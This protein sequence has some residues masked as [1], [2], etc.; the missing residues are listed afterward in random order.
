VS[1]VIC[2][3]CGVREVE[4][5]RKCYATPVCYACLPPPNPLPVRQVADN[6]VSK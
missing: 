5:S 4:E 2:K 3:Q 6:K 1:A